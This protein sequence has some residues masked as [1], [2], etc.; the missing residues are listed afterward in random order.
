[1]VGVFEDSP[2][3]EVDVAR[4]VLVT[5]KTKRSKIRD[6]LASKLFDKFERDRQ[7]QYDPFSDSDPVIQDSK[8]GMENL[9]SMSNPVEIDSLYGALGFVEP[10]PRRAKEHQV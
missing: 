3:H 7:Y 6:G 2:S 10:C 8:A 1:M 4:T 9:L 5:K